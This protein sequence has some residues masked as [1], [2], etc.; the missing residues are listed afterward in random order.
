MPSIYSFKPRFQKLLL[1]CAAML[2]RTGI[3]ANM[4]T[5]FAIFWS[6]LYGAA[7]YLYHENRLLFLLLPAVMLVRMAL[8]ALDG[9]LARDFNQESALGALLNEVGDVLSDTFLCLPFA[10]VVP[11]RPALVVAVIFFSILS[12]FIGVLGSV[13][14]GS[15]R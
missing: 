10:V 4:V 13:I 1:P 5:L 7:L 8:N 12:E 15:R 9:M 3:T 2:H 6:A 14:A 11:A